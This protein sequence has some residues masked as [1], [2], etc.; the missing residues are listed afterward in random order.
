MKLLDSVGPPWEQVLFESTGRSL[1][2][3]QHIIG[4]GL[5]GDE[6]CYGYDGDLLGFDERGNRTVLTEAE[7]HELADFMI[8][9]WQ[10]FR[11]TGT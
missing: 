6:L 3:H 10:K 7:R 11:E 4:I 5:K 9:R 8:A 2:A 1:Y